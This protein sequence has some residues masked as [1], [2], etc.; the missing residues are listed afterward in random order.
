MTRP[1]DRQ[2]VVLDTNIL[3]SSLLSNGPPALIVDWI[4]EGKLFPIYDGHI[5]SEYW[6]VLSRPR[7]GFSSGQVD[8]LI[9]NIVRVGFG[10][11]DGVSSTVKMTDES[12]R[13]F[14]DAAKTAKAFLI[15][16]NS[17]HYPQEPFIITPAAFVKLPRFQ[18][19]R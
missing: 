9:N 15:T 8:C 19:Y 13:K 2:K 12:D 10:I 3:V 11:E 5:L 7:F 14:Y 18:S 1:Y 6:D 16:G 4:A 17:K